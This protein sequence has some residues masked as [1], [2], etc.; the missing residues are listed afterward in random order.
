MGAG[1]EVAALIALGEEALDAAEVLDGGG[2]AGDDFAVPVI[3]GSADAELDLVALRA[4]GWGVAVGLV[5][6]D[7]AAA[8]TA[9]AA[10]GV[11]ANE[12]ER[13][14]RKLLLQDRVGA[15]LS[16]GVAYEAG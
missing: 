6:E 8:H 7:D 9:E 11:G 15:V 1:H 3:L 12:A 10:W 13:S 2:G 16:F 5:E 14:T 4:S